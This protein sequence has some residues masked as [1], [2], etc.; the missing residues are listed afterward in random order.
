MTILP[1]QIK[2]SVQKGMQV[3]L[4]HYKLIP[5]IAKIGSKSDTTD[6]RGS[7]KKRVT[8][9]ISPVNFVIGNGQGS[10][11][12]FVIPAHLPGKSVPPSH[13]LSCHSLLPPLQIQEKFS[14]N[15]Q[16][17]IYS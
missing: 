17:P 15:L 11:K 2:N 16:E 13:H 6:V 9:K 4:T 1:S 5:F 7:T 3:S 10:G 12:R 14:Q 8:H